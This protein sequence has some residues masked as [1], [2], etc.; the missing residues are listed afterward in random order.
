M[1][2]QTFHPFLAKQRRLGYQPMRLHHYIGSLRRLGKIRQ[3][4]KHDLRMRG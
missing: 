2:I 1:N 4:A 3:N